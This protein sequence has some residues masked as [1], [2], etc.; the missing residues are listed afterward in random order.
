MSEVIRR[1][2]DRAARHPEL[3]VTEAPGWIEVRPPGVA[4]FAI[5]LVDQ[6]TSYTVYFEGWHEECA[7]MDEALDLVAMGL[8]DSVRLRVVRRGTVDCSWTL[9]VRTPDGWE[10]E[11]TTGR[12]LFPFWKRRE[13]RYLQNSVI[14][15]HLVE[16]S[17]DTEEPTWTLKQL[18][19]DNSGKVTIIRRCVEP[20]VSV[21]D[22]RYGWVAYLTF[23][24]EPHDASGLPTSEDSDA[25]GKVE[26]IEI[27][28]LEADGLGVFV[29]VVLNDGAKDFLFYTRDP[30]EFL[31]R[32]G[33]IRDG[34]T[35][36]RVGCEIQPDVD[37][38]QY[39]DL[40]QDTSTR[41]GTS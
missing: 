26:E 32:A 30:E 38:E 16:P 20:P 14:R 40:A 41:S 3:L 23:L 15:D 18:V 7:G 21:G 27:P 39:R 22:Q 13:M 2:R 34:A 25:L 6:A 17:K 5:V 19:D 29:A 11:S 9:E 12:L 35:R 4:S 8:S 1:I 10:A 37:W 28:K 36:F 24:F 33:P 31:K